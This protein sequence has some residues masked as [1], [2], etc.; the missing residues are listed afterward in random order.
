MKQGSKKKNG[1]KNKRLRLAIFALCLV[2]LTLV[3]GV[4]VYKN[5]DA[6]SNRKHECYY[7]LRLNLDRIFT[8][9]R[10]KE[11]DESAIP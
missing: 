3:T 10:L 1:G 9:V 7:Q 6:I 5:K 8:E 4:F 11:R 2:A